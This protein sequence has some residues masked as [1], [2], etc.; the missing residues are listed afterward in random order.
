MEQLGH[1]NAKEEVTFAGTVLAHRTKQ[2]WCAL[3]GHPDRVYRAAN[4]AIWRL[5]DDATA[6]EIRHEIGSVLDEDRPGPA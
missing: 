3:R 2:G 1:D 4:T 5:P 6:E